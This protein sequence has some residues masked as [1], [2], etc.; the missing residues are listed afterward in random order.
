[1]LPMQ[2]SLHSSTTTVVRMLRK[3]HLPWISVLIKLLLSME[4]E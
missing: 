1:M 2:I 4:G 3:R